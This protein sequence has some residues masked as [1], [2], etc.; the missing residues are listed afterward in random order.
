MIPKLSP[1]P[2]APNDLGSNEHPQMNCDDK[3]HDREALAGHLEALRAAGKKI[4]FTNGCFDVLH[5][6]HL[7]YLWAARGQGDCL[8]VAVNSDESLRRL[9]GPD[10]PIMNATQRKRVLAGF[11]CV[12]Y[13]TEFAEETPH[14]LL[15]LF[16]PDILIKGATYSIDGV[17]GREV[18][19]AYGGKVMTLELTEGKSTTAI[20]EKIRSAT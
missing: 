1:G 9:K 5:V 2:T 15:E 10:R 14:A 16:R 7:R 19:E 4:V 8:V 18:V 3:I 12:D 13:V 17:V 6:G 20:I 11:A